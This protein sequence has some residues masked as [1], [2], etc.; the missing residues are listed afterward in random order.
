MRQIDVFVFACLWIAFEFRNKLASAEMDAG[1]N[2]DARK[3]F[4]FILDENPKFTSAW[5]NLGFLLLSVDHNIQGADLHYD[6][7]LALDPDNEQALLNKTGALFYR[8]KNSD[9]K[10]LLQKILK[11][12]PDNDKARV[13]IKSLK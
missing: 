8:Q 9:A 5:I 3:N 2:E 13:L 11:L 7:A 12:Y 6:K 4:Q 1:R 10:K